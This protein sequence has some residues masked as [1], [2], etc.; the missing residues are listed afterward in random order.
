MNLLPNDEVI[1]G[2]RPEHVVPIEQAPSAALKLKL[3]VHN[4]EYL[5]SERILYARHEAERFGDK[6]IIAR[7]PS[8]ARYT[9]G[10]R[11]EFAV[12]EEHLRFF[13]RKTEKR[14]QPRTM[15]WQ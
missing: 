5:G 7:L 3:L 6:V 13:D 2:F 11:R 8:S 10:E 14:T 4:L 12:A 1:V 15:T 9:I